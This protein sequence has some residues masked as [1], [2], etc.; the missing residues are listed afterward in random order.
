LY[1]EAE[2]KASVRA[3]FKR[4]DLSKTGTISPLELKAIP[5]TPLI[6]PTQPPS[7]P[8]PHHHHHPRKAMLRELGWFDH[9]T[10]ECFEAADTNPHD[11]ELSFEEFSKLYESFS[12]E[13]KSWIL[14]LNLNLNLILNL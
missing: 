10:D 6:N 11:G 1:W 4:Y 3:V 2:R 14:I 5:S 9:I 13:V 8:P 7:N 12:S